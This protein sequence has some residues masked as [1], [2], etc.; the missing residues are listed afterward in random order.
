MHCITAMSY[1]KFICSSVTSH[2]SF[3]VSCLVS[4]CGIQIVCSNDYCLSCSIHACIMFRLIENAHYRP[5]LVL[6][7]KLTN[8][9]IVL[10][11]Y[12]VSD[13]HTGLSPYYLLL[14]V[15]RYAC[16]AELHLGKRH[17]SVDDTCNFKTYIILPCDPNLESPKAVLMKDHN[18]NS[19]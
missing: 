7:I 15:N 3:N 5:Y 1:D 13:V 18:Q 19:R 11:L 2:I 10:Y 17:C 6:V 4:A 12:P 9:V 8:I 16:F 14:Y